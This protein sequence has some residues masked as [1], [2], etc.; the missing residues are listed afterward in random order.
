MILT[1]FQNDVVTITYDDELR[2][3]RAEWNGFISGQQ[4][5]DVVQKCI[6]LMN[7]YEPLRWLGDNRKL[8]A[9]RQA[10]QDWFVANVIPKIVASSLRRNATVV[11]EDLFN[12]MAV[13]QIVKRA[14]NLGDMVVKDFE[15]VET[16][17]AWL[18]EPIVVQEQA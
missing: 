9:L 12:K 2:L 4:F 11:S 6:D 17:M 10:D 8:R 3:G 5:R 15:D 7:E 14:D 1:Y 13:E 16:A 18:A